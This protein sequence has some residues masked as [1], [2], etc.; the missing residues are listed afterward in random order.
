MQI[1]N[2]DRSITINYQQSG[3]DVIRT[4]DYP[5]GNFGKKVFAKNEADDDALDLVENYD[6]Q[7]I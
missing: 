6:F 2:E 4:A 5:S 3:N 1:T 7:F